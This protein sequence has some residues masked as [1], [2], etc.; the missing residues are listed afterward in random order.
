MKSPRRRLPWFGSKGME[1][2]GSD[3]VFQEDEGEGEDNGRF[4]GW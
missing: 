3:M 2:G 1:V 4:P